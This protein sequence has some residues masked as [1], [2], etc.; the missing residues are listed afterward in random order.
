MGDG[1]IA[2]A[3]NPQ[4]ASAFRHCPYPSLWLVPYFLARM[5]SETVRLLEMV[6]DPPISKS[7]RFS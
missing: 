3:A 4:S 2:I 6:L 5:A 1:I 7:F